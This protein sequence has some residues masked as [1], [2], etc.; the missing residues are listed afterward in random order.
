MIGLWNRV[1]GQLQTAM[2]LS[3]LVPIYREVSASLRLE[4]ST[5]CGFTNMDEKGDIES[6][7]SDQVFCNGSMKLLAI[8]SYKLQWF[9]VQVS[10]SLRL[11]LSTDCGF[12]N[13]DEKEDNLFLNS[14]H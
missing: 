11:E 4:L 8:F 2:V 13:M 10:A 6:Y 12:T 1:T 9:W 3:P 14:L 7:I 5:D